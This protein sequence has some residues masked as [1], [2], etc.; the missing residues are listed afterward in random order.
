MSTKT[1]SGVTP[2]G[3]SSHGECQADCHGDC[4]GD[5]HCDC[6]SQAEGSHDTAEFLEG[7]LLQERMAK[8]KH[9]IVVLS[10]KGGVGKS[11]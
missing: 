4:Q 10:G 9:K 2:A 5:C 3:E 7:Q 11:T 8:I 6:G 1:E